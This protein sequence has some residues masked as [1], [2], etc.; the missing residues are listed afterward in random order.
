MN[1][2]E[3]IDYNKV[4]TVKLVIPSG[5]NAR[6]S[7]CYMN[8]SKLHMQYDRDVFLDN[9]LAS[10]TE[11]LDRVGNKNPV[12]L[13]ITGNEPTYDPELLKTV[14]EILK[15]SGIKKRLLRVTITS[16]GYH[17]REVIPYL[18]GVVDYVNI[19][20]HDFRLDK[21]RQIMGWQT[22]SFSE[23]REIVRSL[24]EH[25][26]TTSAVSVIHKP[27][28]NFRGWLSTFVEWCKEAGFIALR[29]R[30][31]VFW[32]NPEIFDKY[33]A[34]TIANEKYAVITHELTP[35]S[36]WCRLRRN[37]GFRLFFL[38]GVPDTSVV[39]KGI[40]YVVDDDGKAYCDFYKETRLQDYPFE[41]GRIYDVLKE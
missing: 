6:C 23:Y 16:N 22:L 26:I 14:L 27:I 18:D 35:D 37:D 21:R 9:F 24:R 8:D 34:D 13:D 32:D 5:C 17:L 41:I 31:N 39:T 20:V 28:E 2:I 10:I 40:E 33:M 11:I 15:Q 12:S 36:H 25:N 29:L 3:R 7:F 4:I 30:Y 1:Y 38:R 19:S